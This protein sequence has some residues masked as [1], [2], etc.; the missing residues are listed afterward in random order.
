MPK[1][2]DASGGKMPPDELALHAH[3]NLLHGRRNPAWQHEFT[4]GIGPKRPAAAHGSQGDRH[5][6]VRKM[7]LPALDPLPF[8]AYADGDQGCFIPF[9]QNQIGPAG[10]VPAGRFENLVRLGGMDE[11]FSGEVGAGK[12]AGLPGLL[13]VGGL[14]DA[15]EHKVEL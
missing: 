4:V 7:L 12:K 6:N 14:G 13:P 8:H 3:P 9:Q 5:E 10:I 1:G 11:T 2:K 15:V